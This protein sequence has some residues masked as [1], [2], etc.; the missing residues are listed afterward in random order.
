MNILDQP[1]FRRIMYFKFFM[2]IFIWGL[3]PLLIP[4]EVFPKLG[5]FFGPNEIMLTR[6]WGLIVL[7][8]SLVYLYIYKN[9]HTKLSKYL[10]LFGV[11]D[12]GGVGVLNLIL[13]FVFKFPIIIYIQAPFQLFFGYWF[14]KFYNDGNFK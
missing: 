11:I 8:D 12:N 10:F 2:V 1:L 9:R 6:I 5:L 3:I 13:S 7:M 4:I 14:L